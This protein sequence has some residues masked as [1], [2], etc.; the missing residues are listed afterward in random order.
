MT[1]LVMTAYTIDFLR[2]LL[3]AMMMPAMPPARVGAVVVSVGIRAGDMA[4]KRRTAPAAG[5]SADDAARAPAHRV[6]SRRAYA[7]TERAADNRAGAFSAIRSNGAA[8]AAAYRAA[9]DGA[10]ATAYGAAQGRAGRPANR[11]A[12]SIVQIAREDRQGTQCGQ[13]DHRCRYSNTNVFLSHVRPLILVKMTAQSI[14]SR[15]KANVAVWFGGRK[16]CNE[17]C[18]NHDRPL[19]RE[20]IPRRPPPGE[21]VT[22]RYRRYRRAL[23]T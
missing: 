21:A 22:G 2:L 13:C 16:R 4:A 18:R 1:L 20:L 19:A 8:R 7:A 23:T 6:A 17:T 14:S 3:V 11:P 15:R 10:G 9:D 5:S 12:E